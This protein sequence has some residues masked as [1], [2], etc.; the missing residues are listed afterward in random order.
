MLGYLRRS[1]SSAAIISGG[2]RISTWR[3]GRRI[4]FLSSARRAT[5]AAGRSHG[6]RFA[7]KDSLSTNEFGHASAYC[8]GFRSLTGLLF[9]G[10]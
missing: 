10:S 8:L 6:L 7:S 1:S 3:I 2:R 9:K 4:S 5:R